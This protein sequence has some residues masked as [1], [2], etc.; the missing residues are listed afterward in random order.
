VPGKHAPELNRGLR[1]GSAS[2]A[3]VAILSLN[4]SAGAA[5]HGP[6]YPLSARW[7]F[8]D[9]A[10]A[11][12]D[13]SGESAVDEELNAAVEK[14]LREAYAVQLARM[15]RPAP[16]DAPTDLEIAISNPC[17]RILKTP[18]GRIARVES[19]AAIGAGN[20][21]IAEVSPWGEAPALG[22]DWMGNAGDRASQECAANFETAFANSEQM[23][24]WLFARKLEPIGSTVAWPSRGE[25]VAFGDV[26][27]GAMAGAGEEMASAFTAHFGFANRWFLIQ[28]VAAKWSPS[29]TAAP[30]GRNYR[31]TAD[32]GA[33]D[34][35]L[36][37]GGVLRLGR[38]SELRAG[39]G[40]H[41]LFGVAEANYQ[42][43]SSSYSTTSPVVFAAAQTS[44][45][46]SRSGTRLRLG[47][48]VRKYF[49]TTVTLPE[50]SRTMPAADVYFGVFV[51][52]ELVTSPARR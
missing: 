52:F 6:L 37:G 4:R 49:N 15:F 51:G 2:L 30:A 28:G 40:I 3:L 13:A 1:P 35:G 26:G 43:A 32:L 39:A 24:S 5:T 50:L 38:A 16:A 47:I 29:F 17:I 10:D 42:G 31:L 27:I 14:R 48:E 23:I 34:L 44:I 25:W 9:R 8:T 22:D 7:S 33:Y 18:Q 41:Q 19:R 45:V 11:A 12:C 36:E 21:R 20:D 46:P